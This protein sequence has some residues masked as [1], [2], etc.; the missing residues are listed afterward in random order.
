TSERLNNLTD[1]NV[2]SRIVKFNKKNLASFYLTKAVN[3][4]IDISLSDKEIKEWID[5]IQYIYTYSERKVANENRPSLHTFGIAIDIIPKN[6][7]RY[8]YWLWTSDFVEEWWNV[9]DDKKVH[10]PNKII[11]I[12]EKNGFCWGGYWNRFDIMHFEFRPEIAI[13]LFLLN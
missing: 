12:F 4:I 11:E 3:E 6:K 10:F 1:V 2:F 8:I 9:K 13:N 5:S 7:N